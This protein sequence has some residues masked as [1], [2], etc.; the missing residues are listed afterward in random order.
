MNSS[1]HEITVITTSVLRVDYFTNMI[2]ISTGQVRIRRFGEA[3]RQ[4][5]LPSQAHYW[6]NSSEQLVIYSP[7]GGC[8]G[9]AAFRNAPRCLL[10]CKISLSYSRTVVITPLRSGRYTCC[11]TYLFKIKHSLTATCTATR[12]HRSPVLPYARSLFPSP[13]FPAHLHGLLLASCPYP[14]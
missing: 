2:G 3:F 10:C 9:I 6:P 5:M 13:S 8:S 14:L 4:L 11:S 7:R 12:H 1:Q